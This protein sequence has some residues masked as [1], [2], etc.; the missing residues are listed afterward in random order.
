M[1]VFKEGDK[2][3]CIEATEP[4]VLGV[5]YTFKRYPDVFEHL[6]I[7]ENDYNWYSS[8]FV[9]ATPLNLALT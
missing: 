6:N 1:R 2:L 7:E 9:L 4:L 8:R 5:V 3:L